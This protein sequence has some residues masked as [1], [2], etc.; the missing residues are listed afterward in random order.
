MTSVG[1]QSALS[2]S[3]NDDFFGC[4]LP[5]S[6]IFLSMKIILEDVHEV[7]QQP[8][9]SPAAVPSSA[10]TDQWPF[11]PWSKEQSAIIERFGDSSRIEILGGKDDRGKMV[12]LIRNRI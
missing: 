8:V 4:L 5:V 9:Q 6:A 3:A 12:L 11:D 2:W 10:L 7:I 1:L